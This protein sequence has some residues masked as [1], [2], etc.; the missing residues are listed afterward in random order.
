MFKSRGFTKQ[1]CIYI[2][3]LIDH[4]LVNMVTTVQIC[5]GY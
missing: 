2:T 1:C 5:E 3:V 4:F